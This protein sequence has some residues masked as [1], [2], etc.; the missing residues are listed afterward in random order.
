MYVP[1][2]K[3]FSWNLF[4]WNFNILYK[5]LICL[6]PYEVSATGTRKIEHKSL[7]S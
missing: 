7:K 2:L 3:K 4:H 1:T 5:L 6:I